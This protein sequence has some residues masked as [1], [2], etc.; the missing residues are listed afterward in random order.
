MTKTPPPPAVSPRAGRTL[1]LV[2]IGVVAAVVAAAALVAVLLVSSDDGA[3]EDSAVVTLPATP[4]PDDTA[5][6]AGPEPGSPGAGPDTDDPRLP[7]ELQGVAL[8]VEI[9]GDPLPPLNDGDDPAIGTRPPVLVAYDADVA[10]GAVYT[11]SPDIDGPVML[12][13]LAHWCPAC[14]EEV[15]KLV[16]LEQQGRLPDDLAV[17]GVL[18]S[19]APDRPNFP[20]TAWLDGFGWPWATVA[21]GIDFDHDPPTWAAADAFGLTSYPYVVIWDDGVVVDR[22]GGMLGT[23]DLANRIAAAVS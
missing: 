18:T 6:P 22:W 10:S 23:D 1:S 7:P 19:A 8:P 14:N 5:D 12:V 21:D 4:D 16:E 11:I 15:P 20:P 9:E 17:Y 3:D 2:L 13:F